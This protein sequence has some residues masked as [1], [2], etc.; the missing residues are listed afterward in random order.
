MSRKEYSPGRL[1]LRYG[2][3]VNLRVYVCSI[4][5]FWDEIYIDGAVIESSHG[6]GFKTPLEAI[7]DF[8]KYAFTVGVRLDASV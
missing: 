2:S 3:G 1:L 6:T 4:Y 5:W 8:E 7:A